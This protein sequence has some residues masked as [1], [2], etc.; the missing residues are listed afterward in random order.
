M[1]KTNTLKKKEPTRGE[2]IAMA[3]FIPVM[4][5][6]GWMVWYG[7]F[8]MAPA[9]ETSQSIST[10]SQA[11]MTPDQ[12]K[13]WDASKAGKICLAHPTW[14]H[15]ACQIIAAGKVTVGMDEEQA[16]A[17][18]GTPDDINR[19]TTAAGTREQWV[20]GY[21]SY[22]YFDNGVLTSIQN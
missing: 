8:G 21:S 19:T 6:I 16:K 1:D 22:L 17:A 5:W 11:T 12:Q 9:T 4:V 14:S 7:F 20:Y 3:L 13:T 18:W 2:K 15:E 10:P